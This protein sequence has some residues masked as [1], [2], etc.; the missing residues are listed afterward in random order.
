MSKSK[1]RARAQSGIIFRNGKLWDAKE[2]EKSPENKKIYR[3]ALKEAAREEAADFLEANKAP[4][5]ETKI[6]V[7]AP[8]FCTRC[9]RQ[10]KPGSQ[11]YTAHTN[12]AAD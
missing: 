7:A 12:H 11:V 9:N 2:W 3:E 10:H 5:Q 6:S 1:N 4:L 8:Y